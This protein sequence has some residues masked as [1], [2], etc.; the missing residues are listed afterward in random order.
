MK[1]APSGAPSPIFFL[2]S[3]LPGGVLKLPLCVP[4]PKREVEMGY[5]RDWPGSGPRTV[6][7][8]RATEMWMDGERMKIRNQKFETRR[9][10]IRISRTFP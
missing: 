9:I 10:W 3:K 2:I 1:T 6:R 8:W 5:S 7:V 4:M